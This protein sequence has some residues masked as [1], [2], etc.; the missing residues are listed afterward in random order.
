MKK[1]FNLIDDPDSDLINFKFTDILG[2]W[3][4]ITYH[5]SAV[6]ENQILHGIMFDG[7][8]LP[9]WRGIEQS[10]MILIPD[11]NTAWVDVYA[12]IRTINVI[13]SVKDPNTNTLYTR[14]PR[15]TAIRAENYV[16][17]SGIADKTCFGP[18][19]EFFIFDE[20]EFST[21]TE[22]SFFRIA[23]DE[24]PNNASAKGN[25]LKFGHHPIK[26]KAYCAAA[27]KDVDA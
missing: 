18:E 16:L 2:Q 24:S 22:N 9:G 1:L 12:D 17:K 26:K 20:V 7:S 25:E 6:D 11:M 5:A 10:D 13:C 8:S 21:H 14:D 23:T 3:H 4:D 27:P 15:S 19:P